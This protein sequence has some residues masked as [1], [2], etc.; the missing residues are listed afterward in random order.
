VGGEQRCPSALDG[1]STTPIAS[2]QQNTRL[3]GLD[4]N[5]ATPL[6]R[7]QSFT[8]ERVS[9]AALSP[10]HSLPP[11][12][13]PLPAY[14]APSAASG[15][16]TGE[17]QSHFAAFAAEQHPDPMIEVVQISPASLS[18]INSFLDQLLYNFLSTARSTSLASLRPAVTEVL[19]PRLAKDA[20]AGADEELKEFLGGGDDE[21]LTAFH[22]GQ[23]PRGDWDL[24]HVWKLTR[25][26]C[27]VYTRLG[28]LEEDDE[29][30][31]IEQEQLDG[32][33]GGPRRFSS[34]LGTVSPAAAIFLTSII[35][36][37]GEHTLLIAGEAARN[38]FLSR[39]SP[40]DPNA[41]QASPGPSAE[42]LVVEEGDTEK[43]ALD[44]TF[45]RLWRTW[46]RRV[47]SPSHSMSRPISRDSFYRRG[48]TSMFAG[49]S[50]DGSVTTIEDTYDREDMRIRPNVAEVLYEQD[51]SDIPLPMTENDVNE[52]EIP[53]IARQEEDAP[54]DG[55]K[56]PIATAKLRPQ[57]MFAFPSGADLPT[58]TSPLSPDSE[59][60][61][62]RTAV[63]RV[64]S[65]SLPTP[66]Q[67]P[68]SSPLEEPLAESTFATPLEAA[69][70]MEDLSV[71][72]SNEEHLKTPTAD[73][74]SLQRESKEEEEHS[75]PGIVAGLVAGAVS[76][77]AAAAAATHIFT[78]TK[79]DSGND[80]EMPKDASD[81]A[82]K[83]DRTIERQEIEGRLDEEEA[84]ARTPMASTMN[85]PQISQ[86]L[87][88]ELSG[89]NSQSRRTSRASEIYVYVKQPHHGRDPSLTTTE[90]GDDYDYRN[91]PLD[92]EVGTQG[93]AD[94]EDL[95]LSDNEAQTPSQK[96]EPKAF[97]LS[98][99]PVGKNRSSE[100]PVQREDV[101][102]PGTEI[103][104]GTATILV[105]PTSANSRIPGA[106]NG[107]PPLTPLRELMEAA[108]D[109]SDEA[110]RSSATPSQKHDSLAS[111]E[112][113]PSGQSGRS[114]T[115]S[116]YI[117]NKH[118]SASSRFSENRNQ[119]VVL[120]QPS[121][122]TSTT[123]SN[124]DRDR[125][126]VQRVTPPPLTPREA[127]ATRTQR[128]ESIGSID[129]RP[130][131]GGSTTSRLSR[132]QT[133]PLRTSIDGAGDSRRDTVG[134][135]SFD[136][137]VKS[138]QTI[139]YTLTPQNMREME[140]SLA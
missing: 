135:V 51:P 108:H 34:H 41:Q 129:K 70:P 11:S 5:G 90:A 72:D 127:G 16:V 39:M 25:L 120:P 92:H 83:S 7:S 85:V 82:N 66:M 105:S 40:Q 15:I 124:I 33:A 62:V 65:R 133:L 64:R 78:V 117:Q 73:S 107:V 30:E 122:T 104:T 57:S 111:Q 14:I 58:P 61:E 3:D 87:V 119:V 137:L 50:R 21:E 96:E 99:P 103:G 24:E 109:T 12:V 123:T 37:V 49:S 91:D 29:D 55:S 79:P 45:G 130:L 44:R 19:K 101:N 2:M 136:N 95:A 81:P 17:H 48:H 31:F 54:E 6:N 53:G 35:E 89:G 86:H 102:G 118:S 32:S 140:V 77:G 47:R 132:K 134:P 69:N 121:T 1:P 68:Y 128:S 97:V 43:I 36:F 116:S 139:Q 38:R 113:A 98:P 13:N 100:Y 67:T 42:R 9:M 28:D 138:G 71:P 63:G 76:V 18:L 59:V 46:R 52:I 106:E 60:M 115:R 10:V 88:G 26:R 94:P 84:S 22:G 4:G 131:T 74:H 75:K 125:A 126:G 23:E 56:T 112:R 93:G 27:M 8:G 20:I 110:S 80:A 114:D